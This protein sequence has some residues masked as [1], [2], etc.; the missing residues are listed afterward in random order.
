MKKLMTMVLLFV[1]LQSWSQGF[2]GTVKWTMKMEITDPKLKAEMEQSQKKMNDPATQ[3]KMKEMQAKMNDPQMKAMMEANPQ[4]KAQMENA[5]KMMQGGGMDAMTPKGFTVKLKGGN[6]LT[7]IE[8]AM[9]QEI[10]HQKDKEQGVRLDRQN[11]TYSPL[12]TYT[13]NSNPTS[14]PPKITKTTETAKILGYNCVKYL[15]ETRMPNGMPTT[16]TIWT[17]TD[18][19]DFDLKGLAR[20]RMGQ[21]MSIF[22][23]GMEGVPLK[24][25]MTMKEGNMLM[26]V[27]EIKRESLNAADFTIPSDFKEVKSQGGR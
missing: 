20:Q 1:V 11:K 8:G 19:K 23:E 14:T 2:E 24:T 5:M 17:T 13:A 27:V 15:V 7:L 4:M 10:L 12:P 25:E 26:E 6:T 22:H 3:A 18:L 21:G 16:Q 9:P